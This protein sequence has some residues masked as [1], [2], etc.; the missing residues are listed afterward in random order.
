MMAQPYV[1]PGIVATVNRAKARAFA[2]R[3]LLQGTEQV[4]F[5]RDQNED[6]IPQP[7]GPFEVL[8][9][10]PEPDVRARQGQASSSS[11]LTG[12][13]LSDDPDLDAQRGDTFT[14][15]SGATG[16]VAATPLDAGAYMRVPFSLAG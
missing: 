9:V 14:L 1:T 2:T 7:F 13:F 16:T 12:E 8:V 4:E 11:E 15:A 5:W 6:G 10:I 3:K